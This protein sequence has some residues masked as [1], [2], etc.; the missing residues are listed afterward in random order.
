MQT[1]WYLC[2]IGSYPEHE[3]DHLKKADNLS[4]QHPDIF[5]GDIYAMLE[6]SAVIERNKKGEGD[7]Y[8][9]LPIIPRVGDTLQFAGWQVQVSRVILS[10]DWNSKTGI[11]EGLFVSARIS[12][13]DDV[14]PELVDARFSIDSKCSKGVHKWES[15]ARRGLDQ[16][17]YAWELKHEDYIESTDENGENYYRWHTRIRPVA[18]DI[19]SVQ[20]RRWCVIAVELSSANSSVDGQLDLQEAH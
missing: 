3:G 14:I 13:R 5:F 10:T 6:G 4:V 19:I 18:G 2:E 7:W 11:K 15:F 17:Y 8:V 1:Q 16:Q 20:N 9:W 12:I